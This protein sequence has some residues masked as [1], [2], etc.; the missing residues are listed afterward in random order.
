MILSEENALALQSALLPPSEAFNSWNQLL[1]LVPFDDFEHSTYR[2]VPSIYLNLK[3]L[4]NVKILDRIKGFYKFCWARN[5]N[6][7]ARFLPIAKEL[8]N[9]GIEYRLL[10]GAAINLISEN[11]GSRTMGDIDIVLSKFDLNYFNKIAYENGFSK[12]YFTN[13]PQDPSSTIDSEINYSHPS[14]AEIDV[15]IVENYSRHEIINLIFRDKPSIVNFQGIDFKLPSI[16]HL[17]IHS[18]VHGAKKVGPGDQIQTLCDL[19]MLIELVDINKFAKLTKKV[20]LRKDL[21]ENLLSLQR[22]RGFD[23]KIPLLSQ[24]SKIAEI[25]LNVYNF[26]SKYM[27]NF[28]LYQIIKKRKVPRMV[29]AKVKTQFNGKKFLYYIWLRFGQLRPFENLVC[30]FLNGFLPNPEKFINH[31]EFLL[32]DSNSSEIRSKIVVS[33]V[34][35][36]SND[37]RFRFMLVRQNQIQFKSAKLTSESF[38]DWNWVVFCNG[39]LVGTTTENSKGEFLFDLRNLSGELEFSLRS[40]LHACEYCHKLLDDLKLEIIA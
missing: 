14:G 21:N 11:F 25:Y 20:P 1:N 17:I 36:N 7:F 31:G 8:N 40:P 4:S 32:F 22:I 37:W 39:K 6:L 29:L 10:K 3:N 28:R 30:R 34:V 19:N 24:T 38:V 16:E 9:A 13:C 26:I 35:K 27:F 15:H 12:K 2:I 33:N 18:I 23:S 5:S